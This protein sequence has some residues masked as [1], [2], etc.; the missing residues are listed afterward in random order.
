MAAMEDQLDH[1]A[2]WPLRH[3]D[4]RAPPTPVPRLALNTAARADRPAVTACYEPMLCLVLQG[5]KE[6]MFGDQVLRYDPA[7]YFIASVELPASG[8]IVE[9]SPERPY[10]SPSPAPGPR[11]AG[12]PA[13]RGAAPPDAEPGAQASR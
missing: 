8:C 5:A 13:S 9:A 7:C 12:R 4:G 10:L 2:P 3:A 6:V 11:R 1:S